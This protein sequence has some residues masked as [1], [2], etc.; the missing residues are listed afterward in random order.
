MFYNKNQLVELLKIGPK[1]LLIDEAQYLDGD[2]SVIATYLLKNDH[3]IFDSH[4]IGNPVFPGNLLSELACQSAMISVYQDNLTNT[5]RG[6]LRSVDFTFY[7]KIE[8]QDNGMQQLLCTIKL[9][10]EKRGISKFKANIFL[11]KGTGLLVCAGN[12][13]HAKSLVKIKN[14]KI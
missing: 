6:L 5:D 8:F 9:I 2:K 1:F 3:W 14:G 11:D 7:K 13:V 12:I 4:L 10:E